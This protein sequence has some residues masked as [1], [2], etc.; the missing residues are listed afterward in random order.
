MKECCEDYVKWRSENDKCPECG[1][2]L[3]SEKNM[4]KGMFD[5]YKL[6][7]DLYD[8]H[9][10][11]KSEWKYDIHKDWC[12]RTKKMSIAELLERTKCGY[13][14]KE[15]VLELVDRWIGDKLIKPIKP[16]KIEKFKNYPVSANR[17]AFKINE[18]IDHINKEA[19]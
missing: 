10:K 14:N 11:P 12:I 2:K 19:P 7:N 17:C 1:S 3:E 16:K 8:K 5:W 9:H 15:D 13:Y 18:I 4:C 6:G